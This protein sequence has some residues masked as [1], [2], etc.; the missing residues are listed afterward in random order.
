MRIEDLR[1]F[2]TNC[3]DRLIEVSGDFIYYAE[4]KVEEGLNSLFLLEYNRMTKRERIIANYILPLFQLFQRYDH[5][6]GKRRQRCL[7]SAR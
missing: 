4:E 5:Y 7:D 6:H 2:F 1:N 3:N